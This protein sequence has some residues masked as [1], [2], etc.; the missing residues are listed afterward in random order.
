M[1]ISANENLNRE[2]QSLREQL[3]RQ[4]KLASLGMLTAGIAH[5]I[6]NPLNFILNFAKVADSVRTDLDELL[7]SPSVSLNDAQ[8]E[9]ID[10]G[11]Q[12]LADNLRRI[13]EHGTRALDIVQGILLQSRGRDDAYVPV[14][15]V[16]LTGEYVRLSY[17]AMRAGYK[18]FNVSLS[19]SYEPDI[20]LVRLVPQDF[21]RVVLNLMNNACYAVWHKALQA[22]SGYAPAIRISLRCD[23]SHLVF[24]IEDN[25]EGMDAETSRKLFEA[26][27]TTKPA[28][29]GTGLGMTI[30]RELVEEKHRGH[31]AFESSPGAYTRFTIRIPL[32]L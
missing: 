7:C 32:D 4:E 27:Y 9:D 17:H 13:I 20:P 23:E 1:K 16:R 10:A 24:V 11:M 19:E 12:L 26:F 30:V 2:L 15:V 25:G 31:I 21:S 6:R 5:E 8:R 29:H 22:P 14:D 18:D 28:G 3:K